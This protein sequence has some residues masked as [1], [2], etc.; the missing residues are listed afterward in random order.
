M[1][2]TKPL[3]EWLMNNKPMSHFT[4]YKNTFC[5]LFKSKERENLHMEEDEVLDGGQTNAPKRS[6]FM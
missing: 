5:V 3:T 6:G 1:T 4:C 2:W